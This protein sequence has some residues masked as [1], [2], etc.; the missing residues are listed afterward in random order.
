MS[1]FPSPEQAAAIHSEHDRYMIR[2]S[3][4]SGKTSVLVAKY[5]YHVAEK[6]LSPDSI[7]TITFTRKAAT[8]MKERIVPM[9]QSLGLEDEAQVAESG[10]IQTIHSF[11]E[12]MLRENSVAAGLDPNFGVVEGADSTFLM[13]N[14][15][16]RVLE[17]PGEDNECMLR[18]VQYY[19]GKQH[20][21]KNKDII[22][23]L[24]KLVSDGLSELRGSGLRPNVLDPIYRFPD[25]YR[26]HVNQLIIES[27]PEAVRDALP[28]YEGSLSERLKA[29]RK[30]LKRPIKQFMNGTISHEAS[31]DHL[32]LTCGLGQLC[33][34]VWREMEAVMMAEGTYDFALMESQAVQLLESNPSVKDRVNRQYGLI[35]VDEAQDLNPIQNR[36]LTQFSSASQMLVGDPQQSIYGFRLAE[37]KLF[38]ERCKVLPCLALRAN[39]RSSPQILRF[40]D[41]LFSKVWDHYQPMS[42]DYAGLSAFDS[43]PPADYTGIEVWSSSKKAIAP[44]WC[45]QQV[46]NLIAG[47]VAPGDIAIL[48]LSARIGVK[49]MA[50]LDKLGHLA[51]V[52]GGSESFYTH[53]VLRD[54]ANALLLCADSTNKF[55]LLAVMGSPF[56]RLSTDGIVELAAM[57]FADFDITAH[58]PLLESDR[59][60]WNEFLEW[61]EEVRVAADR[62]AAWEVIG[63]LYNR[64][65][66]LAVLAE[67]RNAK[68]DLANARKVFELAAKSPDMGPV[69]FAERVRNVRRIDHRE[70]EPPPIDADENIIK[71][72]TVHKA[73]GLEFPVVVVPELERSKRHTRNV[74]VDKSAGVIDI[75]PEKTLPLHTSWLQLRDNQRSDEESIRVGYVAMTRAKQR[76]CIGVRTTAVAPTLSHSVLQM[77]DFDGELPRGL[78]IR[79]DEPVEGTLDD[80]T[81]N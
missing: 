81:V 46:S 55:A 8:E 80:P 53:L 79:K 34:K 52:E 40:V 17:Y 3:A 28:H 27:L 2:A 64:T 14:A 62:R 76:L 36:L 13:E 59:A 65:K 15:L 54:V 10:P 60:I 31:H 25:A 20:Y 9:L 69:A 77:F 41:D 32:D 12:R 4:G 24:A 68:Q 29:V 47:G 18:L 21:S 45:A 43:P 48:V 61:Y 63:S 50:E 70:G 26:H 71:I 66:Y 37:V 1:Q 74:R 5:V 56:V 39:H 35:L 23:F 38:E 42:N 49:I 78:V 72:M 67:G 73:K 7:L 16:R 19:S 33:L 6:G 22:S 11:C 57:D 44:D 51:Q 75:C 30:D 58:V